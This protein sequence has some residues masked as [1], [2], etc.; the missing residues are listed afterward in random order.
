GD[1]KFGIDHDTEEEVFIKII[2]FGKSNR[3]L[4]GED[5]VQQIERESRAFNH[6]REL[7]E[8]CLEHNLRRVARLIS[9]GVVESD[10]GQ[11]DYAFMVFEKAMSNGKVENFVDA[12]NGL[13]F[14]LQLLKDVC[15]GLHQ[16]HQRSIAHQDIKPSNILKVDEKGISR[17]KITDLGR[18]SRKGTAIDHDLNAFACQPV[19]APPDRLYR[20]PVDDWELKRITGDLYLFGSLIWQ[21]ALGT[22]GSLTSVWMSQ[23]REP[24]KPHNFNDTYDQVLPHL[25]DVFEEIYKA[26][27]AECNTDL[28]RELI[29]I[30]KQL[31]SPDPLKRG[32]PSFQRRLDRHSLQPFVSKLDRLLKQFHAKGARLIAQ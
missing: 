23:L 14:R 1:G 16:L 28:E 18:A 10:D 11:P 20:A 26:G 17:G 21:Y 2:V 30:A 4:H 31:T 3:R 12:A 8:L 13:G 24:L 29:D 19:Y 7:L 25:I 22:P 32:A 9:A 27:I 5:A 6:E 15:V